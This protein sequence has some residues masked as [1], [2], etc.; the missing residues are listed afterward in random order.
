MKQF[1][2]ES[3]TDNGIYIFKSTGRAKSTVHTHNFIE[4]IYIVCGN[5]KEWVD[6]REYTVKRGDLIFIGLNETHNFA[7]LDSEFAF[8]NI[9]L[10]PQLADSRIFDK[11]L[12]DKPCDIIRF[13]RGRD[14]LESLLESMLNECKQ[15]ESGYF[16][17]LSAYINILLTKIKRRLSPQQ[18]KEDVWSKILNYIN[19]NFDGRLTATDIAERFYYNPSYFSRVFSQKTGKTFS[20]YLLD[21]RLKKAAKLLTETDMP[22]DGIA[23]MC[24]FGDRSTF[25]RSFN[26]KYSASP[27]AYREK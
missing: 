25:Y 22:A 2:A 12:L 4:L 9:L 26:K 13:F 23:Q 3:Y 24:G 21:L 14:E 10:K 19:E 15:K 8:Y 18:Q 6:G 1:K 20:K 11:E 27:G 16:N 17:V 5:G 7:P